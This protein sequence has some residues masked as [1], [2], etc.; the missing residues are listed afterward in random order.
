MVRTATLA[1]PTPSQQQQQQQQQQPS[2]S[3]QKS[4]LETVLLTEL[5]QGATSQLS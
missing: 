5:V 1:D 2:P 4:V 3:Q